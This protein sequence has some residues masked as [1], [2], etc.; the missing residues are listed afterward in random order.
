[1]A[2]RRRSIVRSGENR[3]APP[4]ARDHQANTYASFPSRWFRLPPSEG[5]TRHRIFRYVAFA[6]LAGAFRYGA[7]LHSTERD[8]GNRAAENWRR[9]LDS[10]APANSD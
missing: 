3:R 5:T 4:S 2:T 8:A 7:L 9:V 6:W 1:M 10:R